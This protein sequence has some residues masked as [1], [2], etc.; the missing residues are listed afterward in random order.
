MYISSSDGMFFLLIISGSDFSTAVLRSLSPVYW[1]WFKG[2]AFT[3][4][5]YSE[6]IVLS[7]RRL[8]DLDIQGI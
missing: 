8:A 4:Q 2:S 3:V 6:P 1:K 5:G 7:N